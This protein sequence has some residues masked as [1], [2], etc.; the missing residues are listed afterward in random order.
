[1]AAVVVAAVLASALLRSTVAELYL[2]PSGSMEPLLRQGDRI[3]VDREA[4]ASAPVERGD[5]V[6]VDG[7]GS[8]AP[9]DSRPAPVRWG[10]DALQWLGLAPDTTA[11]VKRVAGVGGDTV[12]CCTAAGLLEVNGRPVPEHYL[13]GPPPASRIEFTAE[14]PE[15]RLFLLGDNRHASEDSR[16]LL[17]APGGGMIPESMVIGKVD[18]VVWPPGRR[19]GVPAGDGR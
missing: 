4:Y 3:S 15:G 12:S 17:G 11:Y 8:F 5:V 1:M 16:S 9:Y 19:D 2:I 6:V 10:G 7:E 14:V 13:A 18:A